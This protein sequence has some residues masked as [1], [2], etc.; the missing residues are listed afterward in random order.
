MIDDH[1]DQAGILLLP[2]GFN[3][4]G[5]TVYA[6]PVAVPQCRVQHQVE[7]VR[8]DTGD[9]VVSTTQVWLLPTQDAKPGAW[10]FHADKMYLVQKVYHGQAP[11]NE[12]AYKKLYLGV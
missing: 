11:D 2:S 9:S 1:L 7:L 3:A 10:F 8:T 5:E 4:H 12:L 6:A